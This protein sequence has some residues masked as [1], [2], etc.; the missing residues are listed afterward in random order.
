VLCD[1]VKQKSLTS[2]EARLMRLKE[3]ATELEQTNTLPAAATDRLTELSDQWTSTSQRIS[4]FSNHC[5][6]HS[7]YGV[8]P[9][10]YDNS[11]SGVM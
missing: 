2:Q 5:S 3:Q 7:T 8:L 11:L 6:M 4:E 10:M 9:A 1:Q